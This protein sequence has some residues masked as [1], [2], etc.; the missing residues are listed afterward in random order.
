MLII[1]VVGL[2][3]TVSVLTVPTSPWRHVLL[4]L[5]VLVALPQALLAVT[6]IAPLPVPQS[7]IKLVEFPPPNTYV[8]TGEVGYAQFNE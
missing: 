2:G 3:D 8:A 7:I 1:P 4:Q 6:L 5:L